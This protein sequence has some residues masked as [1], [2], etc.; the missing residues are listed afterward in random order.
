MDEVWLVWG[1]M[2]NWVFG[3]C[4]VRYFDL[5]GIVVIFFVLINISVGY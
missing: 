2:S 3:M 1:M 5:V 4:L